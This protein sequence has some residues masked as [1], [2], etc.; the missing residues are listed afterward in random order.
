MFTHTLDE[1]FQAVE[2]HNPLDPRS[3][4]EPMDYVCGSMS[5][6]TGTEDHKQNMQGI[7]L[8]PNPAGNWLAISHQ[9][10]TTAIQVELFDLSGKLV[11]ADHF[12]GTAALTHRMEISALPAG[13]YFVK[14]ST[15]SEVF[16][17]K[18]IKQ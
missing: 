5:A 8:Y 17:K 15:G 13:M 7:E 2:V 12:D 14:V 11:T 18:I 16:T 10:A 3:L 4:C 9:Q 6:P 1:V